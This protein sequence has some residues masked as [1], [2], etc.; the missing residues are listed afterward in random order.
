MKS[1]PLDFIHIGLGKCAST[2]LQGVFHNEPN[3]CYVDLNKVV[4]AAVENASKGADT[5]GFPNVNID[6][7][8]SREDKDEE[9]LVASS[10]DFTFV[11]EPEHYHSVKNLYRLSA[12]FLGRG[13]LSSKILL[14][15]RDP[16]EWLRASHE[17]SIK[18]GGHYPYK[19]F[20]YENKNYLKDSLN[21]REVIGFYSE[22]FNVITFSADELKQNP[23]TFWSSFSNRLGVGKP[24]QEALDHVSKFRLGANAS[25]NERT[26]KLAT[27]N[28]FSAIKK[29]CLQGMNDYFAAIPEEAKASLLYFEHERWSNR[30]IVEFVS[31]EQ[32][33]ELL[34]LLTDMDRNDFAK[35]FI[36]E[37]MRDHLLEHFIEP[38][39][40]I[41]TIS[42]ELKDTYVNSIESAVA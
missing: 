36:D 3:Y 28:R 41:D 5:S 31:D 6:I 30:R 40:G 12:H 14:M 35:V 32:L 23:D 9:F 27:L 26:L 22:F 7:G 42:P 34:G 38:L 17:Q 20:F 25:L 1:K 4:N 10:E 39:G 19:K 21:I 8:F 24:S 15:I 33:S 2:Y 29:E 37:E 13:G 16:I 11:C 18:S